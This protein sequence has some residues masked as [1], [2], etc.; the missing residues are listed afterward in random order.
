MTQE[1]VITIAQEATK[2]LLLVTAPLLI[3]ALVVGLAV[4]IFQAVTQIQE[5]TLTFVPKI[6]AVFVTILLISSWMLGKM[7]DFTRELLFNIPFY[8]R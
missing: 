3:V 5:M 4:T 2:V 6:I 8:V 7:V 1:L